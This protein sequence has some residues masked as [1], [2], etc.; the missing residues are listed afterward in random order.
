M[1]S[2][3]KLLT[4][5]SHFYKLQQTLEQLGLKLEVLISSAKLVF[6][7]LQQ[8]EAK[9]DVEEMLQGRHLP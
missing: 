2:I 6:D 8:V 1:N 5:K 7:C 9:W 3:M 4:Y